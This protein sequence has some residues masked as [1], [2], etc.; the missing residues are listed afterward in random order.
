MNRAELNFDWLED[1]AM[2]V[3]SQ[4]GED[5]VLQAIFATIGT[6]NK[7]CM[8]C[9]ASDGLFFSNTRHLIEQG[10]NAVLVEGDRSKF[11]RLHANSE[12]FGERV[13]CV[14]VQV[15]NENRLEGILKQCGAP[16]DIDLAV[17]DVDGQDYFL[18]NSLLRYRPRV[19]VCEFDFA[20]DFDFIPP[21]RGQGQAGARAIQALGVGKFY[22]P[23]YR[24]ET[25]F[26]FVKQPLEK[27]LSGSREERLK[28]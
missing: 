11:Q 7:W 25:N 18:F 14:P 6:Q 19:V 4:W 5:G 3:Y 23:V 12:G 8:E 16:I 28:Q 13:K 1:C 2:N 20:A 26:I 17:I 21:L 15:D 24:S 10:W 9:G 27:V 22:W